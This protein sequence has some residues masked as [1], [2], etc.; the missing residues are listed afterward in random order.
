MS[1]APSIEA[2]RP[3]ASINPARILNLV[4]FGFLVVVP[5]CLAYAVAVRRTASFF[6]LVH[7]TYIFITIVYPALAATA[8]VAAF[9]LWR[10]TTQRAW[11]TA[12][13][14]HAAT[15]A[16]LLGFRLYA[17]HL[18]PHRLQI[19]RVAITSPKIEKPIRIV[20]ISDFQPAA[21]GAYEQR[22][23]QTIRELEP[24][25]LIHTGDLLQP[26]PPATYESEL[27]KVE[28]L[29]ATTN[30]PLGKYN[31]LGDTDGPITG[32]LQ[33]G[34]GGITTLINDDVT[35]E[36]GSTHLRILGLTRELSRDNTLARLRI[37]PWI[38]AADANDFTILFGHAPD[39]I[40]TAR[41]F[42]I[43]LCLAGH[44]HGGQVRIPFFGPIVTMTSL[45]RK[46]ARGYHQI[47]K[48]RLNVSAG[49]GA[50]HAEGLPSIRVNC[51][52]EITVITIRPE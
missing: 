21:I 10:K 2:T 28:Q 52:P 29:L 45:P 5:A 7:V 42:P 8:A 41:D 44:T 51:P 36:H 4:L 43:D 11:K 1:D 9:L 6:Y 25:L 31:V 50:E 14:L 3:R 34:R 17:T 26:L 19:R 27:P 46:L 18:E 39:Y 20:H 32:A 30:P 40:Q 37:N 47:G 22:V 33:A 15:A 23:I 38:D 48:T 35:I 13:I 49:I 16:L 12:A 24:D